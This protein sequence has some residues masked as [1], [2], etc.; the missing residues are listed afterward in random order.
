MLD[1]FPLL[2]EGKTVGELTVER[3]QLYTWFEA[4]CR[5]LDETLWCAWAVGDL[6]E[7]RL[8]VLEPCGGGLSIRRRF[9]GRM[10][11][12]AVRFQEAA[13]TAIYTETPGSWKPLTHPERAFQTPWLRQL[14]GREPEALIREEG[15]RRCVAVPYDPARPFPLT[16]LFCFAQIRR[17]AGR[18]WAV[19]RFDGENPVF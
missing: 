12:P 19:F 9:S 7:I 18:N 3:E 1:K 8:G 11:Q 2:R 15:E 16:R 17:I 14:L 10:V 13:T 5:P 4:R 6:G